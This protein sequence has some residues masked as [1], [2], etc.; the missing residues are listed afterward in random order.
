MIG[1]FAVLALLLAIFALV[2]EIPAAAVIAIFIWG[3]AAFVVL[4][5][6]QVRIMTLVKD[7]PALASTSNHSALAD[8]V[9][10]RSGR[11]YVGSQR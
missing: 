10:P 3:V 1:G 4:P 8:W 11:L 6:L 5:G 9:F 2:D 7:A